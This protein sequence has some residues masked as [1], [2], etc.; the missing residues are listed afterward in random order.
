MIEIPVPIPIGGNTC[1]FVR[2]SP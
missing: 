2:V 1:P